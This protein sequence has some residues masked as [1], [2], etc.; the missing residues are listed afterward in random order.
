MSKVK[1]GE[2]LSKEAFEIVKLEDFIHIEA[3]IECSKCGNTHFT[4]NEVFASEEFYK[5]GW[6]VLKNKI[7]CSSCLHGKDKDH[8]FVKD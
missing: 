3:S 1:E 8:T 4:E 6:R 7:F 2:Q 5:D